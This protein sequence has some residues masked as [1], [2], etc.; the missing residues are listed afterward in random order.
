MKYLT[1]VLK[2]EESFEYLKEEGTVIIGD[3]VAPVSQVFHSLRDCLSDTG[4]LVPT[5]SKRF[6]Y[7]KILTLQLEYRPNT[8]Y[9]LLLVQLYINPQLEPVWRRDPI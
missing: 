7:V 1:V 2:S 5:N 3:Q 9:V 6:R 4:L 8:F